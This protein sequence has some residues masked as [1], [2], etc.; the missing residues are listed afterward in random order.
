MED[1]FPVPYFL[2]NPQISSRH[3]NK[4][5]ITKTIV[6]DQYAIGCVNH[7]ACCAKTYPIV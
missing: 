5:I 1:T 2:F 3:V 4:P 7:S 6:L